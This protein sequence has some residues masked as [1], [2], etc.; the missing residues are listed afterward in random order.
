MELRS[1]SI[2]VEDN[3]RETCKLAGVD[4]KTILYKIYGN[5]LFIYTDRPGLIIG[6]QGDVY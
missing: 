5:T 4:P 2:F 6:K 3:L 1:L